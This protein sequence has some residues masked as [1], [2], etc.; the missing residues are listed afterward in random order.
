MRAGDFS[1]LLDQ[2]NPYV[3]RKD[4]SGS[5][6]PVLIKDPQ[7]ANACTVADQSG[8]FP[9]N[10]IPS[11]RLSPNGVGILNAWPIPNLTTFIGGH[12]NWFPPKL[13]TIDQRQDTGEIDVHLT[14][15]QR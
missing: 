14:A 13:H 15:K 7:S 2:N 10:I 4:S 8:F 5:K 1:E 3:T 11:N 9:G 6:I 12:G